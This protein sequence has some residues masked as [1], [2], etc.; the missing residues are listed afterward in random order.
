MDPKSSFSVTPVLKQVIEHRIQELEC[1]KE[2][3]ERRYLSD[4]E[5]M[6]ESSIIKRISSLLKDIEHLTLQITEDDEWLVETIRRIVEQAPNDKTLANTVSM[7]KLLKFEADMRN[8]IKKHSNRL[9]VSRLHT[10]LLKEAVLTKN[11]INATGE[12]LGSLALNDDF[13]LIGNDAKGCY[14]EFERSITSLA[15]IDIDPEV[16]NTY[17]TSLFEGGEYNEFQGIRDAMQAYGAELVDKGLEMDEDDLKWAIADL[18]KKEF[19]DLETKKALGEYLQSPIALREL[20]AT[21][22]MKSFRDW[23]YKNA[24]TGLSVKTYRSANGQCHFVVKEDIIDMLFLH[25][26]GQGWASKMRQCLRDFMDNSTSFSP[27][28][29][30]ESESERHSFFLSNPQTPIHQF[31]AQN[32]VSTFAYQPPPPPPPPP[33][34]YNVRSLHTQCRSS[35]DRIYRRQRVKNNCTK[36]H[37]YLKSPKYP[38]DLQTLEN[39]RYNVYK[40]HF[41][42]SRLPTQSSCTT[43]TTTTEVIQAE[44]LKTLITEC[45]LG[46]ALSPSFRVSA[47]TFERLASTIPHDTILTILKYLGVPDVFLNFFGRFLRVKLRIESSPQDTMVPERSCGVSFG[48]NLELFFSEAVLF[49]LE[50]AVHKETGAYVYRLYDRCYCLGIPEITF[51]AEMEL[52][53]FCDIMGLKSYDTCSTGELSI[54]FLKFNFQTSTSPKSSTILEIDHTKVA[55]YI[56]EVK[57]R[58]D[59]CSSVLEWIR[60]WNKTIGTYAAHLFGTPTDN[61]GA[62]HRE[63][64]RTAYDFIYLSL[65]DDG[66]LTIHVTNLLK[67]HTDIVKY[68]L[69]VEPFI[70]LPKAY[71]GLGVKSPFVTLSLSAKAREPVTAQIQQYLSLED[72]YYIKMRELYTDR[73]PVEQQTK[74]Q[75]ILKDDK[76]KMTSVL[77]LP[78]NTK[79]TRTPVPFITKD[80]LFK[81]RERANYLET[82]VGDEFTSPNLELVR[83]Y[84]KIMDECIYYVDGSTKVTRLLRQLGGKGGRKYWSE[85]RAEDQW[86]IQIYSDECFEQYGTLDIW[87]SDGVPVEVYN[88]V[89]GKDWDDD[90][91]F[92]S[93]DSC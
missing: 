39:E 23:N 64:V 21:L 15:N 67:P 60:E 86:I 29:L 33:P 11:S 65:L 77:G 80:E 32:M 41:F 43:R 63:A 88:E 62:T 49:F 87:W 24:E 44:L 18:M 74:I 79:L 53:R 57:K 91:G 3:F 13:E 48:H 14:E 46:E 52:A 61:F 92:G 7:T 35:K 68:P 12:E 31:S 9:E 59:T 71:G 85:L 93:C 89:R 76:S 90:E 69:A 4:E 83:L 78:T 28:P 72:E 56:H 25:Y 36:M 73:L 40:Q 70:Y 58:L 54:G 50:L 37:R 55:E 81:H 34:M 45:K 8:E 38:P 84:R 66:D 6:Q 2:I 42:V 51:K 1:A 17:L 19:I 30:P 5:H 82:I 22:H 16:I 75:A 26:C 20:V 10:S 27:Q 47:T